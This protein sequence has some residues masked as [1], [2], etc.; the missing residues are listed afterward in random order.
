MSEQWFDKEFI[1]PKEL[2]EVIGVT[3]RTIRRR[4]NAGKIKAERIIGSTGWEYQIP[5]N[6]A[7]R[8][9]MAEKD[10]EDSPGDNMDDHMDDRSSPW[11]E[12]VSEDDQ[13]SNIHEQQMNALVQYAQAREELAYVRGELRSVLDERDYLRERIEYLEKALAQNQENWITTWREKTAAEQ[14][15]MAATK[16]KPSFLKRI[17]GR[18]NE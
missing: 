3:D 11:R 5:I 2:S 1:T 13:S 4:I 12:S 9:V 6:E 17:F 8:V 14:E 16:K 10:N 15:I 7:Q 18:K